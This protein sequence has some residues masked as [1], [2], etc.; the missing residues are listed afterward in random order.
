MGRVSRARADLRRARRA[1]RKLE[2]EQGELI[3]DLA[4]TM[5][6]LDLESL[7]TIQAGLDRIERH[8]GFERARVIRLDEELE[9]LVEQRREKRREAWEDVRHAL[10]Q[11]GPSVLDVVGDIVLVAASPREERIALASKTL[12]EHVDIPIPPRDVARLAER[13][14][15]ALED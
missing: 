3:E 13:I 15:E 7:A 12:L 8:I 14:V 4:D 2:E 10:R 1:V 6:E 9:E 11:F 5:A